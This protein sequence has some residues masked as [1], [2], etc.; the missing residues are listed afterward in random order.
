MLGAVL[1]FTFAGQIRKM[2]SA[3]AAH[4]LN[5]TPLLIGQFLLTIYGGYFGAGLGVLMLA[6][7]TH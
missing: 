6:L 4:G 5:L 7:L 3:H 2:A 1:A